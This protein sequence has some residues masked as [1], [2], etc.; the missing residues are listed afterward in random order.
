MAKLS[1]IF[2]NT[3]GNFLLGVGGVNPAELHL[4]RQQQEQ[5]AAKYRLST[6]VDLA[7]AN[8]VDRIPAS[9]LQQAG[10]GIQDDVEVPPL[11]D[12]IAQKDNAG[13]IIDFT[14]VPKPRGGRTMVAGPSSPGAPRLE[15]DPVTGALTWFYPPSSATPESPVTQ[16]SGTP[17]PNPSGGGKGVFTVSGGMTK[18]QRKV[19]EEFAKDYNDFVAQGGQSDP[20]KLV[21]GL[22]DAI[23][24]LE[25]TNATGRGMGLIGRRGRTF[26]NPKAGVIE[27]QVRDAVQ[28]NLRLIL[29]G[30]FAER[31]GDNLVRTAYNPGLPEKEVAKRLQSLSTQMKLALKAK[32]DAVSYYEQHGT[33]RGYKG[34]Q[35]SIADFQRAAQGKDKSLLGEVEF[36]QQSGGASP[37]GPHGPSVVQNGVTYNWNPLTGQYE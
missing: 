12:V 23:I 4:K 33:L 24:E 5:E 8:A 36:G 9:V 37:E 17:T 10:I 25:K 20:V 30:Q 2:L 16:P 28:R 32:Q 18:A 27:D 13:N 29:G 31:E 7:K 3:L 1:D 15:P 11:Y 19:D 6:F 21:Y 22:D 26:I 34:K 14:H 35:Y